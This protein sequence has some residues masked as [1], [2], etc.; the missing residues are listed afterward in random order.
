MF[1][2]SRQEIFL[3]TQTLELGFLLLMD[4]MLFEPRRMGC[5]CWVTGLIKGI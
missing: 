3:E 2:W 5:G 4:L 1:L